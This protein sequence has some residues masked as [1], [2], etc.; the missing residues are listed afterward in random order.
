MVAAVSVP[1]GTELL[2]RAGAAQLPQS[3][4]LRYDVR[5]NASSDANAEYAAAASVRAIFLGGARSRAGFA[6]QVP[7]AAGVSVAAL[8]FF[9]AA[10]VRMPSL[11][12]C[13]HATE[14]ACC[15]CLLCE[16]S[17]SDLKVSWQCLQHGAVSLK[18]FGTSVLTRSTCGGRHE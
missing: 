14:Q 4:L 9:A 15:K 1:L 10:P 7:G 12:S 11:L 17:S 16:P 3:G 2:A 6:A 13:A 18:V 8:P 5:L